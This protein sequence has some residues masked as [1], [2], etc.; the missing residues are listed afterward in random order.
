MEILKDKTEN[1]QAIND[2]L[3]HNFIG[4][5]RNEIDKVSCRENDNERVFTNSEIKEL[6]GKFINSYKK[7]EIID[8]GSRK[9]RK[10]VVE[11]PK[12]PYD[13]V[14]TRKITITETLQIRE[15]DGEGN[16]IRI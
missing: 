3:T 11:L 13:Q 14:V 12:I 7:E 4:R 10:I 9:Q 2:E 1:S 5:L 8:G 6:I 15:V 16:P